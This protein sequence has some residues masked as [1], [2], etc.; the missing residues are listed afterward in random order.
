MNSREELLETLVTD[1]G[2]VRPVPDPRLL[3]GCWLVL[4]AA[5]VVG[6]THAFGPLRPTA[7]AQLQAHPRF[8]AE[9]LLGVVTF[10]AL[11]ALAFRVAIPGASSA[12]LKWLAVTAGGLWVSA[13]VIGLV[14]PALEPSMLGKRDHCYLETLFYALPPMLAVLYWQQRLYA[15]SPARSAVVAGVAAGSL[16][17]LYMQLA[18]M[19]AP[20]HILLFH[21]GPGAAVGLLAPLLVLGYRRYRVSR[22]SAGTG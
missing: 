16:P 19:Y 2:P 9:M 8:F 4:S 12:T 3:A 11:G 22:G 18:C 17:A 7:L 6:L 14:A 5:C 20:S 10:L 1:L 15:L 13:I 21:I